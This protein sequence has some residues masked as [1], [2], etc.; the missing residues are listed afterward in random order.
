MPSRQRRILVAGLEHLIDKS[1]RH[2]ALL[3]ELGSVRVLIYSRDITKVSRGTAERFDLGWEEVPRSTAADVRHLSRLLRRFRPSHL[4]LYHDAQSDM[5]HMGY[6]AAARA[7]RVPIVTVCRGG[8]LL[9]WESARR[10]RRRAVTL[11]LRAARMILYKELHMPAQLQRLQIPEDRCVF[12][13]NRTTIDPDE[14]AN[15]R[16]RM[17]VL[18]LNSWKPFRRPDISVEVG[19]RLAPE[20]PNSVFTTGGE[21]TW[22]AEAYSKED[23]S[24]QILDA[25]LEDRVVLQPWAQV[26]AELYARN[27]IFLLPATEVYLNYSL[28]EAMERGLVPVV[29]DVRG[30]DQIVEHGVDGLIA[31]LDPAAFVSATRALLRNPNRTERM[32]KAARDKVRRSFD[33]REGIKELLGRYDQ[34]VWARGNG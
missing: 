19:L 7:L 34:L 10:R 4:E 11:G 23:L 14:P 24:R 22:S 16:D 31:D 8:E 3:G 12:F 27:G 28:L 15:V 32:A 17:N 25:G 6:I 2:Y 18:F 5:A 1:G 26:P 9:Y 30:A 33:L 29:A 13:H 21:R 20:F